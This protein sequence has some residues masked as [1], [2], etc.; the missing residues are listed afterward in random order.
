MSFLPPA[1]QELRQDLLVLGLGAALLFSLCLGARD[2]WNPNEPLYGQAV[3]EMA[4]RSDWTLPTVNGEVFGE[5]PILY[6]WLALAMSKPFGHV[7]ELTLRLPSAL[8]GVASVLLLYLLVLP[9]GG[10]RRAR[11]AAALVATTYSVFWSA[12][13][14]QMDM[15]LAA[16]SLGAILAVTRVVEH[17]LSP[18]RGWPLAGF[19]AGCGLLAKGPVALIC[20]GLPLVAYMAAAR[21][22]SALW[23]PALALGAS[24]MMLVA[25]PWP[26][27]VHARGETALLVEL[28]VRQ[29][30]TR[31]IDPWDH[32]APWWYFLAYFW[33][34]M[35]PWAVFAPLALGLPRR[36]PGEKKLDRLAWIWILSLIGFF[37]LSAS[38][39]SA[40]I[41]PLA[42]AVAI[43]VSG[44]GARWLGSGLERW[45][46]RSLLWL[47]ALIGALLIAGGLY[48][49]FRVLPDYTLI[50]RA[51]QATVVLLLAGGLAILLGLRPGRG[52]QLA[53]PAALFSFVVALYLW[54]A[55]AVLPAADVYKS[56]RAFCEAV[57][58]HVAADQPL[59]A[60][61]PW[62]WRAGYIYYTGRTIPRLESLQE[63]RAYWDRTERVFLIVE[64]DR[65]DEIRP[66][67]DGARPLVASPIGANA[68]YLFSNR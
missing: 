16:C 35:A 30:F 40:Y 56:P 22:L 24:C 29:N 1:R 39:R 26:L 18:W 13:T 4:A 2:L 67:L 68:A 50:G 31:F 32:Q 10:R 38:K 28:V 64:R 6:F 62:K 23:H 3:V 51:G 12:R 49:H 54:A 57:N 19:A 47:T 17:G 61:R 25:A 9:H 60:Y 45:R 58:S 43:L 8:A 7:D 65:L 15:L 42:P 55:C 11:L 33:I 14:V 48:L 46:A 66:V 5:K 27:W 63:L 20:C 36:E 44:L 41:L 34:D 21:R 37:S 59:W 53:A 52:A